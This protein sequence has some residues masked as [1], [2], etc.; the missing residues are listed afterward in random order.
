M[1]EADSKN[2]EA[3]DGLKDSLA[4]IHEECLTLG[5]I[6]ASYLDDMGEG[7]SAQVGVIPEEIDQM[8]YEF[9]HAPSLAEASVA[10]I[11]CAVAITVCSAAFAGLVFQKRRGKPSQLKLLGTGQ[12]KVEDLQRTYQPA[13]FAERIAEAIFCSKEISGKLFDAIVVLLYQKIFEL[14]VFNTEVKGK[15]A[16]LTHNGK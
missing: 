1:S 8:R 13:Y 4:P 9:R 6:L 15:F 12:V 10:E 16:Y 5:M 7:V 14:P 2:V 3:D 11:R